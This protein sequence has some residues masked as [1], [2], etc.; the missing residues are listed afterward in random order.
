MDEEGRKIILAE[1]VADLKEK[2]V[3]SWT[4]S[5]CEADLYGVFCLCDQGFCPGVD[6]MSRDRKRLERDAES[7]LDDTRFLEEFGG[8]ATRL[9]DSLTR[10]IDFRALDAANGLQDDTL[11]IGGTRYSMDDLHYLFLVFVLKRRSVT[12]DT[13]KN[14]LREM[15]LRETEA[16]SLGL[17]LMT[18]AYSPRMVEAVFD[19]LNDSKPFTGLAATSV[20]A[21]KEMLAAL[22]S[23]VSFTS[24]ELDFNTLILRFQEYLTDKTSLVESTIN[25][26]VAAIKNVRLDFLENQDPLLRR[27]LFSTDRLLVQKALEKLKP[28]GGFKRFNMKRYSHP[29]AA[30][31]K[32]VE[33]VADLEGSAESAAAPTPV[34]NKPDDSPASSVSAPPESAPVSV[35]NT[36]DWDNIDEAV[37]CKPLSV[38]YM[39]SEK[40]TC[41]LWRYVYRYIFQKLFELYPIQMNQFVDKPLPKRR[42]PFLLSYE[43]Q[44]SVPIEIKKNVWANGNLGVKSFMRNVKETMDCLGVPYSSFTVRYLKRG[45]VGESLFDDLE[46][47]DLEDLEQPD[48]VEETAEISTD[49]DYLT[50]DWTNP[51]NMTDTKPVQVRYGDKI[52]KCDTWRKV[53]LYVIQNLYSR[54]SRRI[55]FLAAQGIKNFPSFYRFDGEREHY[56]PV[57]D[58]IN[59]YVNLSAKSAVKQMKNL[60]EKL[61]LPYDLFVVHY[62]RGDKTESRCDS[63]EYRGNDSTQSHEVTLLNFSTSDIV[64]DPS[65]L[66]RLEDYPK[67][68]WDNPGEM[69]NTVPLV[70]YY[71]AQVLRFRSWAHVYYFVIKELYSLYKERS[72][73]FVEKGVKFSSHNHPTIRH[74]RFDEDKWLYVNYSANDAVKKMKAVMEALNLLHDSPFVIRYNCLSKRDDENR[75][76]DAELSLLSEQATEIP[77]NSVQI[78]P[79]IEEITRQLLADT[80]I[81]FEEYGFKRFS[82]RYEETTGEPLPSNC[83]VEALVCR[84]GVVYEK[85]EKRKICGVSLGANT[86]V[87]EIIKVAEER[88]NRVFYYRKMFDDNYARLS[89]VNILSW[90]VLRG[91]LKKYSMGEFFAKDFCALT[92]NDSPEEDVARFLQ[93]S[94]EGCAYYDDIVKKLPYLDKEDVKSKL[95]ND[96]RFVSA[97][98]GRVALIDRFEIPLEDVKESRRIVKR[99]IEER[100]FSSLKSLDVSRSVEMWGDDM[101]SALREILYLKFLSDSYDKKNSVISRQ[102]E[103]V[104]VKDV[105]VDY[106]QKLDL[107][108]LDMLRDYERE[109]FGT[110]TRSLEIACQEMIRLD[111]ERFCRLDALKFPIEEVDTVIESCVGSSEAITVKELAS[112]AIFPVV[113]GASWNGFLL[114][115]YIRHK[116][117]RFSLFWERVGKKS[118][119]GIVVPKNKD[120][121]SYEE[122]LA[123]V[124]AAEDFSFFEISAVRIRLEERG[125]NIKDVDLY[126]VIRRA[127]DLRHL[128]S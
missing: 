52:E 56:R 69:T 128:E 124:L 12:F 22:R 98:K 66:S 5:S 37:G 78:S 61:D 24:Q 77:H 21:W 17:S 96:D 65:V 120:F 97:G 38:S 90:E 28:L 104:T 70:V 89:E 11:L 126:A 19:E 55:D 64:S 95:R 107:C 23:G 60:I 102:G 83:N 108:N 50:L 118:P 25:C 73:I 91:F 88:D 103:K 53:Y 92:S 1:F 80:P 16:Q 30:L 93:D 125:F 59:V 27:F 81:P 111:S 13:A 20:S 36:L 67:L 47:E 76:D 14:Y 42:F 54:F 33:F 63:S 26:Y 115:S 117:A 68:N 29:S 58:S 48:V 2:G 85:E 43:S 51:G 10:W 57:K 82:Q 71:N 34:E 62:R 121:A 3:K 110:E 79:K 35:G 75:Q 6:I 41:E 113:D 46:D 39:G 123:H 40:K 31:N 119:E 105:L 15:K 74:L 114:E 32:W 8:D 101:E 7:L 116:S 4:A 9:R 84:V 86:V 49:D 18:L 112:L 99:E 44:F 100:G 72:C 106:C 45:E 109:Y 122:I 127:N 94:G 87:A